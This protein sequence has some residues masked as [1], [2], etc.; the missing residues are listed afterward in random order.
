MTLV[1]WAEHFAELSRRACFINDISHNEPTLCRS[2]VEGKTAI[3]VDDMA[4][5]MGTL[6]MAAELLKDAGAEYVPDIA[7]VL[8]IT[9][10]LHSSMIGEFR[11]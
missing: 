8:E 11:E 5:T 7:A 3:L 1:G 6:C 9:V 4:D 10:S 2:N